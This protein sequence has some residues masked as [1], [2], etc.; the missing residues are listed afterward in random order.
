VLLCVA[1]VPS[2]VLVLVHVFYGV[3]LSAYRPVI[4]DE[5][6]YWHQAL[7]FSHAGFHGGFYTTSE[8]TNPSGLTPFGAHGPGF[9]VLYGLFGAVFG[10]HRHTAVV[11]NLIAIGGAAWVWV[12]LTRLNISR[13]VLAG[14]TLLTFWHMVFWA[15]TG[16]QESLH[17]AGAIVMAACFASA[18]GPAPRRWIVVVGWIML[19]A[20]SFI[21][22]SWIVLLPIWAF[23]TARQAR[24]PV[25]IAAVAGSLV[26]GA[27]ILFAYS[28]TTA[29]YESG[30]F[31]LRT[32]TLSLGLHEIADNV[33]TNLQRIAMTDQFHA[34]ELLER[35]QYWALL[36]AAAV[37]A[38]VLVRRAHSAAHLAVT[39]V[40]MTFALAAML[41]LYQFTNY[42]EHRVLSA[43]LLFGLML[44]VAA[45]GRIGPLLVAGVMLYNVASARTTLAGIEDAWR[46]HFIWDRRGVSEVEHAVDGRVI[47]RPG[48]SRWCNTLLTSQYPPHLIAVPAGIGLSVVRRPE[49]MTLPPRSHYMLL[50][51]LAYA[52]FTRPLKLDPL[53]TLP[54]G[55]LFVNR[56]SGCE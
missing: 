9:A 32:A 24:R 19:G 42:A 13:L 30:F 43:F 52:S 50:D 54:Y 56:E 34:I 41:L 51:A 39:A 11:L 27:V 49:Q 25:R 6:A 53:A 26:Y 37:S 40:A 55:T 18:L 31:F 35:Y 46:D 44:C 33:Q 21:R 5:V 8:V 4:N 7:T 36:L 20:L 28:S 16:M 29:P 22:P 12:S 2:L 10:W 17:H 15:P 38:T 3:P 45:P 47:Y 23:A 14:L 48:A 1:G